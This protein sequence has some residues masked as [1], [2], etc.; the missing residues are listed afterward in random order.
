MARDVIVTHAV[1]IEPKLVCGEQITILA[2]SSLTM[3]YQ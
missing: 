2:D 1:A 3:Y